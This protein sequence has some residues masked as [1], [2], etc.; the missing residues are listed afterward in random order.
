MNSLINRYNDLKEWEAS[1]D[2]NV[3]L[4]CRTLKGMVEWTFY[5]VMLKSFVFY[6]TI[7]NV[8][9]RVIHYFFYFIYIVATYYQLQG[10][11]RSFFDIFVQFLKPLKYGNKRVQM[12]YL[13]SNLI[14]LNSSLYKIQTRRDLCMWKT[15]Q[16]YF[17][18]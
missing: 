5:L 6:E 11:G 12:D 7:L 13:I 14:V 16:I 1:S 9:L 15:H 3:N 2:T 17:Y 10:L 4:A 8:P 18:H